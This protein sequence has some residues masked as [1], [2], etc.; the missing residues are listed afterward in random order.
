MIVRHSAPSEP[1]DDWDTPRLVWRRVL[2]SLIFTA[3]VV[4]LAI[5]IIILV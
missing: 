5:V 2:G 3:F 4:V 1:G